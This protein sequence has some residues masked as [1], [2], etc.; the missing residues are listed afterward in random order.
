[1]FSHRY[2]ARHRVVCSRRGESGNV[3]FYIL[4]AIVLLAALSYAVSSS[5]R[6]GSGD[7][8]NERAK[9]AAS[10]LLEYASS[11]ST[12]VKQLKL[13]GCTDT[14]ISFANTISATSYANTNAPDDGSC[15]IFG[16]AGGGMQYK[17]PQA[18]WLNSAVSTLPY[19]G[20]NLFTGATCINR[21]GTGYTDCED[22]GETAT[23][24]MM[25]VMFLKEKL[26]SE[27]NYQLGIAAKGAPPLVNTSFDAILAGVEFQGAYP[28]TPFRIANAGN[29][30]DGQYSACMELNGLPAGD[31]VFFKVL[32]A[33]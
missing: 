1:M 24:L 7:I 2:R 33:R 30:I 31:Y 23:E 11:I 10:E 28:A 8:S 12:A 17:P 21:V 32:L 13:R 14:E 4:I 5:S 15:N 22:E 27:I 25:A 29:T 3:L 9:L 19:Y 6:S 20:Q 18:E 26:C 16:I